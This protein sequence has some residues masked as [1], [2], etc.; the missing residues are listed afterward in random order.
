MISNILV[1]TLALVGGAGLGFIYFGGLWFTVK[2]LPKVQRPT[3]WVL[4]S[5]FV[6]NA[7]IFFFFYIVVRNGHWER[8]LA[9]LAGFILTRTLLVRRFRPQKKAYEFLK[10]GD[11]T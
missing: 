9:C 7:A 2:K 5:F 10:I 4:G 1:L 11:R 8:L 6:R 3:F